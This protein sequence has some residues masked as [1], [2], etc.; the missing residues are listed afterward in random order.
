MG[1]R[2]FPRNEGEI[3]LTEGDHSFQ[4]TYAKGR[5]H[6][7]PTA[8][9]WFV[10]G[11]GLMRTEL[12]AAGSIPHDAFSAYQVVPEDEPWLQRNFVLHQGEK[13]TH[14]ISVGFPG[15]INYS[16]DMSRGALLHVWKG[17]Y[18]DTSTMWYQRGN[19]QSALPM[20]SVVER[21]GLPSIAPLPDANAA[22]PDSLDDFTFQRYELDSSGAPVFV[23]QLGSLTVRDHIKPDEEN[24]RLVRTIEVDGEGDGYWLLLAESPAIGTQADP[25]FTITDQAVPL[26]LSPDTSFL[27]DDQRM[28]LEVNGAT[29]QIRIRRSERGEQL[30]IPLNRITTAGPFIYNYTW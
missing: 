11:P 10:S 20:G 22:W 6:G 3:Y 14:A 12:T 21:S 28:Y 19:M 17:P 2:E 18:V 1:A 4:L 9:G 30:I 7:A 8:L 15:G 24:R 26:E 23:Y 16:Y 27:I 29:R 25:S 13:R 5:W